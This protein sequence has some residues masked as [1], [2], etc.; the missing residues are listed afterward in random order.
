MHWLIVGAIAAL[1]MGGGGK[2][3]SIMGDAAKGIREFRKG[4]KDD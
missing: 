1:L 3:T 4:L 2:I